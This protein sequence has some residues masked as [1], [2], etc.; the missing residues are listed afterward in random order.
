ML[1]QSVR[2]ESEYESM[3]TLTDRS[4][5]CKTDLAISVLHSFVPSFEKIY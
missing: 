5:L 3:K 4:G 2:S 1:P